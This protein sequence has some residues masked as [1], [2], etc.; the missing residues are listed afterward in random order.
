MMFEI[1]GYI[2]GDG[3]HFRAGC[4]IR[5]VWRVRLADG[6][7]NLGKCDTLCSTMYRWKLVVGVSG[8]SALCAQQAQEMLRALRPCGGD[9]PHVE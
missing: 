8:C 9:V 3:D 7:F 5:D 6:V 4:N 1:M 2:L